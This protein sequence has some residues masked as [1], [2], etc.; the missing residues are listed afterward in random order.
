MGHVLGHVMGHLGRRVVHLYWWMRHLRGVHVWRHLAH[1]KRR[2]TRLLLLLLLMGSRVHLAL[3]RLWLEGGRG[4]ARIL[5]RVAG[6][7]HLARWSTGGYWVEMGDFAGGCRRCSS[8]SGSLNSSCSGFSFS[9]GS[10]NRS[11]SDICRNAAFK[12]KLLGMPIRE[13]VRAEAN[14]LGALLGEN[15]QT[16]LGHQVA[17]VRSV[18][19]PLGDCRRTQS[20]RDALYEYDTHRDEDQQ[21][22]KLLRNNWGGGYQVSKKESGKKKC[23]QWLRRASSPTSAGTPS[24]E[25]H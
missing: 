19:E 18:N 25:G 16:D 10:K 11:F 22:G 2:G 13:C 3:L 1:L 24:G 17:E 9:C 12:L 7:G 21:V 6:D 20:Q 8:H 4:K 15:S 23:L 5:R 14:H